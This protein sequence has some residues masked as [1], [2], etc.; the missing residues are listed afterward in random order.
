MDKNDFDIDFDFESEYGFDPEAFLNSENPGD[1]DLSEFDDNM[2][3]SASEASEEYAADGYEAEQAGEEYYDDE[4]F[5]A[6]IQFPRY[7]QSAEGYGEEAAYEEGTYEEGAYEEDG[8]EE[9]SYEEQ[10]VESEEYPEEEE[11][12]ADKPR[13]KER[14]KLQIKLPKLPKREKSDEPR[15]PTILDKII[16]LYFGPLTHK[17]EKDDKPDVIYDEQGRP[18]RRRKPS[19]MQIIKEVY[20]PPVIACAAL[21]LILFFIFGSI[22]NAFKLKK[23]NDEKAKQDAAIAEQNANKAEEE[24]EILLREAEELVQQYNYKAAIERLETFSG[25]SAEHQQAITA[26]KA[27]YVNLQSQLMEWKDPNAIANLSF[28]VLINEPQRAF[29]DADADVKGLYNRNFVT[30]GEFSKILNQLYSGGYVLVDYNSFVDSA[31]GLDGNKS[32]FAKSIM[33]PDGK[34]PIMI[35]ETMVNYFEYMID[36]NKDG[37][38]DAGGDGFASRLVVSNGEIKAQYVDSNGQTLIGDYDLVPIL[39]TFIKEHPDFSYCG[40]RATLACTGTQG[41]FGYRTNTSYIANRGQAF[42]DQEVADAKL[43]VSALREKGY[44][45]ACFT[46]GNEA[47]RGMS[48]AQIKA[49]IQN[50]QA[51][52]TPV[53]GDVDVMIFAKTS[54]IDDYTGNKFSVL[55]DAGFRIFVNNGNSPKCDVNPTYIRQTRLMVTG[56]AMGWTASMFNGYFDC[57]AVLDMAARVSIPN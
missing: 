11:T 23:I 31:V 25:D 15:N 29:V 7:Q 22:T 28:H 38:A 51:Q 52:I 19:K 54:D 26:K 14:K 20:L 44:T 12:E 43:V 17:Q 5:T 34:K 41:I 3:Y 56:N 45:L 57:N 8:Y 55:Y 4:D 27:E 32:Y 37:E 6:D 10:P 53:I 18:R 39:E 9:G 46:Y 16:D 35:T 33:L 36:S 21:L 2:E 1:F 50:W 40:A 13:R 49:D 47:Y 24:Y 48:V 30:T 42:Y